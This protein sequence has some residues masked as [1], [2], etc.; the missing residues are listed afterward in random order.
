MRPSTGSCS[1]ASLAP[2]NAASSAASLSARPSQR[3]PASAACSVTRAKLSHWHGARAPPPPAGLPAARRS[4]SRRPPDRVAQT[5]RERDHRLDRLLHV[6][7]LDDLAR[8]RA[9]RIRSGSSGCGECRRSAQGTCPSARTPPVAVSRTWKCIRCASSSEISTMTCT[10]ERALER[11]G[12]HPG[13]EVHALEHHRPALGERTPDRG[14]DAH[15]DEP[16]T[17]RRSPRSAD[18]RRRRPPSPPRSSSGGSPAS[19][20]TR[21]TR[22]SSRG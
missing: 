17:A 10:I 12:H 20:R 15:A 5:H 8:P 22:A 16:A 7:V 9:G 21:R 4:A 19:P 11:R 13:H 3:A 18:R 14:V 6:R 1:S 2:E